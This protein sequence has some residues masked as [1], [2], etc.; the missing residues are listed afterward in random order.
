VADE[1]RKLAERTAMSTQEISAMVE[2][3]RSGARAAVDRMQEAVTRVGA[4]VE[5]AEGASTSIRG[6]GSASRDTVGMV[7]EITD[8]I[9]EQ[10]TTSTSIAQQVER[11]AQMSE[12]SSAAAG[13]S[14]DA[15]RE[16]DRL[17]DSM[18]KIVASY[19][20]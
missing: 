7:S 20:L 2:S 13:E 1:V 6:I 16:L 17:A 4:G 14:A 12:E 19:R 15:A 10:S 9:R 5:R 8:A 11:I 3:V 18:Q